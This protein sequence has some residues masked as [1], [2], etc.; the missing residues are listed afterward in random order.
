MANTNH[1]SIR[2]DT[3]SQFDEE[4][5]KLHIK[6]YRAKKNSVAELYLDE[7]EDFLEDPHYAEVE[8]LLRKGR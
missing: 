2:I 5:Q 1:R 3:R 6:D 4:E 8:Y 7:D